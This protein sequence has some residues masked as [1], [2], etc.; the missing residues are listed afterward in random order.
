MSLK[1]CGVKTKSAPN[2][3]NLLH[4]I[5]RDRTL[6]NDYFQD[7]AT[8]NPQSAH[9]KEEITKIA[10]SKVAAI[11]KRDSYDLFFE[12]ACIS[13]K[14]LPPKLAAEAK[15]RISQI[16]TEFE[17][18]AISEHEAQQG[19]EKEKQQVVKTV[20]V[21]NEPVIDPSSG[22]VYEFQAYSRKSCL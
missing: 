10:A 2:R 15:S 22:I 17:I 8:R 4:R 19:I 18:R 1:R 3:E 21:S 13:I 6:L 9:R 14:T 16:I 20:R 7:L 12:S 5:K 11:Q